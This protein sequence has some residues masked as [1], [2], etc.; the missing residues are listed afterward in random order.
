MRP[1]RRLEV[2]L[3]KTD[4]RDLRKLLGSGV[5]QVR[6]VLRAL[7]L[8]ELSSGQSAPAVARNLGLTPKAVRD[9][10]WRHQQGG[11]ERA[12]YERQRPGA[13]P[14]LSTAERQRII[15]MVCSDPPEGRARWTIRLVVEESIKRKLVPKVG[16]ETVRILLESHD[17]KP[18]REKNVV[19]GRT[20]RRVHS[21]DGKRS[22]SV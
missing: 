1:Y 12:L 13:T 6:V 21:E 16:R 10:G 19:R 9:I 3:S 14:L 17:L 7:A 5:Q 2:R 4:E 11:L 8:L 18:W 22:G 15:A 20:R